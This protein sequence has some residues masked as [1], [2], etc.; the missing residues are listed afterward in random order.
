MK[1]HYIDDTR[2]GLAALFV[3]VMSAAVFTAAIRLLQP[4]AEELDTTDELLR[5][6][7]NAARLLESVESLRRG[8]WESH[9]LATRP[10]VA[11]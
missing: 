2:L 4:E 7:R 8:E 10:P 11:A 9:P 1:T 3:G 5:D 6:P